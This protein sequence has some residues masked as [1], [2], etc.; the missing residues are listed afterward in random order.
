MTAFR[1]ALYLMAFVVVGHQHHHHL[2]HHYCH[3]LDP[4]DGDCI[5]DLLALLVVDDAGPIVVDCCNIDAVAF[6]VGHSVNNRK[7]YFLCFFFCFVL[8]KHL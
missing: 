1:P 4:H 3:P 5:A 8:H 6:V 7:T 2:L